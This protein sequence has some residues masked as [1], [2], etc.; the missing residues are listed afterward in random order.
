TQPRD[1]AAAHQAADQ[2]H[3]QAV[4]QHGAA[5]RLT[6]EYGDTGEHAQEYEEVVGGNGIGR[7]PEQNG[8]HRANLRCSESR[9]KR[10][11][12][13][14]GVSRYLTAVRLTGSTPITRLSSSM[15]NVGLWCGEPTN[16]LHHPGL[17]PGVSQAASGIDRK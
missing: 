16:G 17:A 5:L 7:D 10:A 4:V 13:Q 9:R 1:H 3:E 2:D 6:S 12:A 8:S 15:S 11:R 14:V